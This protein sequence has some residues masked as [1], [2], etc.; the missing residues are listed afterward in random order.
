[1]AQSLGQPL[2]RP[3]FEEN[4]EVRA[5]L[6]FKII[7]EKVPQLSPLVENM[8]ARL[9]VFSTLSMKQLLIVN[10]SPRPAII[11]LWSRSGDQ[12]PA[13]SGWH[14]TWARGCAGTARCAVAKTL[15]VQTPD[16]RE[17]GTRKDLSLVW[18]TGAHCI[19]RRG[20]WVILGR[21]KYM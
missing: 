8:W 11:S 15:C 1:M 2:E 9:P 5:S 6:G 21:G 12:K 7:P 10:L 20:H 4:N 19:P 14:G 16:S 17:A 3:Q 13:C 18:E